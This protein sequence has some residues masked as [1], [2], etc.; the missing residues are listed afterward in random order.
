MGV[1]GLEPFRVVVGDIELLSSVHSSSCSSS[2]ISKFAVPLIGASSVP[3]LLRFVFIWAFCDFAGLPSFVVDPWEVFLFIDTLEPDLVRLVFEPLRLKSEVTGLVEGVWD[4][5]RVCCFA[6]P[7][8]STGFPGP[9][10]ESL[11]RPLP[12]DGTLPC[13]WRL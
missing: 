10:L 2:P 8:S 5:D 12:W 11:L 1:F 6:L 4:A 13:G 3:F 7:T 9:S